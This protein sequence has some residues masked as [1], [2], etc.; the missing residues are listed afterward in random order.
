MEVE[1]QL[2]GPE[3]SYELSLFDALKVIIVLAFLILNIFK[4]CF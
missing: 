1:V 2:Y 4:V 3:S